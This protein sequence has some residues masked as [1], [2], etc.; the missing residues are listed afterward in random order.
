MSV[1]VVT[2]RDERDAIIQANFRGARYFVD[3]LDWRD[4]HHYE[5]IKLEEITAIC[6]IQV[7]VETECEPRYYFLYSRYPNEFDWVLRSDNLVVKTGYNRVEIS[8]HL[9]KITVDRRVDQVNYAPKVPLFEDDRVCY[10][11]SQFIPV[12][13][14][15]IPYLS[16]DRLANYGLDLDDV[17]PFV[18]LTMSE[19][20]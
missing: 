5:D 8:N 3:R 6:D 20:L 16:Q 7:I 13:N 10:L 15:L 11:E 9:K 4:Q 12:S 1:R 19:T 18:F 14:G 17:T 2:D